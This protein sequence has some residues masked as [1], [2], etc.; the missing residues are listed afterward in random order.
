M[1]LAQVAHANGAERVYSANLDSVRARNTP[2][3]SRYITA[4]LT[5]ENLG[6][7]LRLMPQ[8]NQQ[9]YGVVIPSSARTPMA[10]ILKQLHAEDSAVAGAFTAMLRQ[11][12]AQ[13]TQRWTALGTLLPTVRAL[14]N[15]S[16]LAARNPQPLL[17]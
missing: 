16:S 17:K 11:S 14:F 10:P 13:L 1:V 6:F 5:A 3:L 12:T 2:S 15:G 4:R 9:L 8:Q 7:L